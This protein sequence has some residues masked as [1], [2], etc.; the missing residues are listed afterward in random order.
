[1]R[2]AIRGLLVPTA[3]LFT[4]ATLA[5]ANASPQPSPRTLFGEVHEHEVAANSAVNITAFTLGY[6]RIPI[7]IMA[8]SRRLRVGASWKGAASPADVLKCIRGYRLRATLKNHPTFA[9]IAAWLMHDSA[10]RLVILPLHNLHFLGGHKTHYIALTFLSARKLFLSDPGLYA[11]AEPVW[12]LEKVLG[13]DLSRSCILV[14][15]AGPRSLP[16]PSI[17]IERT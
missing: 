9:N 7:N 8:V 14:R 16:G 10:R 5:L 11:K 13:G 1:M 2:N 15:P 17:S 6:F 12:Y 3:A 4:A